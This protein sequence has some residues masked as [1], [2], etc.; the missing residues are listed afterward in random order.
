[1]VRKSVVT[2]TSQYILGLRFVDRQGRKILQ[3]A[4]AVALEDGEEKPDWHDVP[5]V[6]EVDN[7]HV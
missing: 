7:S 3:M 1:M 5:Y 6:G 2:L 4:T